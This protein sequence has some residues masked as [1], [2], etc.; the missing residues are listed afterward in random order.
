MFRG[1]WIT[2]ELSVVCNGTQTQTQRVL[3]GDG[4]VATT[5]KLSSTHSSMPVI[6]GQRDRQKPI[7]RKDLRLVSPQFT[8]VQSSEGFSLS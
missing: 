5:Q 3:M 7:L 1:C 2:S 6:Q 8:G 4:V